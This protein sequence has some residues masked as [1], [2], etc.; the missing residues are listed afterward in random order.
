MSKKRQKSGS[1]FYKK[2]SSKNFFFV[3]NKPHIRFL[4][5]SKMYTH[6]LSK[7]SS[8]KKFSKKLKDTRLRCKIHDF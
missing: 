4:K 8:K 6:L 1:F 3:G 2:S 5:Q 7:K